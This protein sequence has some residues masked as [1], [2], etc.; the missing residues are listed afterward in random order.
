MN[1]EVHETMKVTPYELV[2]GQRLRTSLFPSEQTPKMITEEQLEEDGLECESNPPTPPCSE[3]NSLNPPIPPPRNL[4]P[5]SETNSPNPPTPP[6]RS[7][8][9]LPNPPTPPPQ[10]RLLATTEKHQFVSDTDLLL[11]VCWL[12]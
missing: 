10:N 1:T 7:E 2:L 11:G 9:N 3:A 6:P 12:L 4:P 8:V 5:R